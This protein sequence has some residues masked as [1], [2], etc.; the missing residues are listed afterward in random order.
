MTQSVTTAPLAAS[1]RRVLDA[2]LQEQGET[3]LPEACGRFEVGE[4]V[5]GIVEVWGGAEGIVGVHFPR[6]T[7]ERIVALATGRPA[8]FGTV[9]FEDAIS[10]M[11]EMIIVGAKG[12]LADAEV[13]VTRPRLVYEGA[14]DSPAPGVAI[15]IWTECGTF[16][17]WT[18]LQ[19]A[20]G[21]SADGR[22]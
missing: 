22:A 8:A 2:M 10:E 1:A 19:G 6:A 12:E 4:G 13:G 21:A 20:S 11:I 5:A 15:P 17:I 18:A 3:G 7:S 9:N 16:F 14:I